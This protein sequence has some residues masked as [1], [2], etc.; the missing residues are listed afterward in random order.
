MPE[1][2][3][4][5]DT[6]AIFG[7]STGH[8]IHDSYTGFFAPMLPLLIEKFGLSLAIAGSLT[9]FLQ[10]PSLLNPLIG[11]LDDRFNL[12][13]G[14]ILAPAVTGTL[15]SILGILPDVLSLCFILLIAGFSVAVFHATA[16]PIVGRVSGNFIGRGMSIFM[17]G[18]E[19]GRTVG[20]LLFISAISI[21]TI[22]DLYRIAA[23]GW[24]ISAVLLT[25]MKRVRRSESPPLGLLSLLSAANRLILP[26]FIIL[27]GRSFLI[28]SITVFLPT[29]MVREG[30]TLMLAA[31]ALSVY[32]LA[33]VVGALTSGTLSDRYGRRLLLFIGLTASSILIMLLAYAPGWL[34]VP[35]LLLLGFSTLSC[36]PVM[37]AVIQDQ[38]PGHRAMANGFYLAMSFVMRPAAAVIIG[39]IGDWLSLRSSFLITA[40][41]VLATIPAIRWLPERNPQISQIE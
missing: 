17:A 1:R 13:Y 41:I 18:G 37:L 7:I 32:E 24:L 38:I 5:F 36:Q 10:V 25:Q 2:D 4:K 27:I 26:V 29:L 11:Y 22:E 28:S 39:F 20:P 14:L 15:M 23:F 31:G 21:W 3:Q 34:L 40:L 19:L 9:F 12:K 33:G 16:P 30:A 8:F 6:K 35:T